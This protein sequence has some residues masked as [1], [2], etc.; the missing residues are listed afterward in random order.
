ME[1]RHGHLLMPLGWKIAAGVI[2]LAVMLFV[3]KPLLNSVYDGFGWKGGLAAIAII[4]LIGLLI[5]RSDRKRR[6]R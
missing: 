6:G 3:V 2:F 5:E 1:F 4:F